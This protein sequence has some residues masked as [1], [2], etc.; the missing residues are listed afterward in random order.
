[1]HTYRLECAYTI[2]QKRR[3]FKSS[4]ACF[5]IFVNTANF[6]VNTFMSTAGNFMHFLFIIFD[7]CTR[8]WGPLPSILPIS[9]FC[10]SSCM[11]NDRR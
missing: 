10:K 9:G 7:F 4:P 8:Y 11:Y 3:N 1:M 5:R 6:Y 2:L